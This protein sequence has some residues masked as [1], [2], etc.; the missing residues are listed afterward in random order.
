[1][2]A[3]PSAIPADVIR[4]LIADDETLVRAGFRALVESAAD[5]T[6]IGEA[7]TGAQA[8]RVSRQERPD[9]VLMDIKMPVMDGLEATR[10]LAYDSGEPGG[11]RPRVLVV[12]TFDQDE[13]VFAAL[14]HGASGFVLKDSPPELLLDAIR[15]VARGDALLA[16]VVTRR[17]IAEFVRRAPTADFDRSLLAELTGRE[18]DVLDQIAAGRSNAEIADLLMVSVTTVK[19]HVSRLL[20][21][22]QAR[23]RVQLVV[24]AYETGIVV[25]GGPQ[26]TD[27]TGS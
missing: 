13:H 14:R 27:P 11:A 26:W 1:M 6:V 19:T 3:D 9:V 17:L 24:P 15:V 16:P 8:V 12:T 23:D 21:K 22:L 4:V 25:A 20:A 5:L 10:H 7:A 18:R 2:P